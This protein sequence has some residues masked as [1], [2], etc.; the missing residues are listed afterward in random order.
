M[1]VGRR[2]VGPRTQPREEGLWARAGPHTH[3]S[4]Q[5]GV[6]HLLPSTLANPG[7]RPIAHRLERHKPGIALLWDQDLGV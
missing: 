5:D 2:A 6:G 4:S 3:A 1:E 7:D